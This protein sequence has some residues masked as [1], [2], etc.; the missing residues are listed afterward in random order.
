MAVAVFAA[1]L[2]LA[3]G[4]FARASTAAVIEGSNA[5]AFGLLEQ[6]RREQGNLFFSPFS[7]SSAL[8][9]TW[10]GAR[11]TTADQMAQ[12]LGLAV[13]KPDGE[14]HKAFAA[15]HKRLDA[16]AD[17]WEIAVANRLFGQKGEPF[18]PA[19]LGQLNDWYGAALEP[20]DFRRPESARLSINGWV[21]K[22]TRDK[23]K[24]L[25]PAGALDESTLLVVANAIWF[26]GRWAD[27]FDPKATREE[28]FHVSPRQ[29]SKVPIMHRLGTFGFFEN[30]EV[31]LVELPYQGN[32][33]AMVVV[34]PRDRFGLTA[35]EQRLTAEGFETLTGQ[36]RPVGVD[37][38]LPKFQITWEGD[39]SHDLQALGMRGAFSGEA[40]FSG[41]SR[42]GGLFISQV[43]HKAFVE[44]N[45]E[46]TE[47]AAATAVEMARAMSPARPQSFLADHPF[48]FA[49]IERESRAILF[50]GRVA[51]PAAAG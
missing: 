39:L 4:G 5:F 30:D 35:L 22:Q 21:E 18:L 24:E 44:V 19:F 20:V 8:A 37:V 31:S 40:D 27:E 45:E 23:V 6:L 28:P 49:I 41:I 10:A 43:R 14:V 9:M 33:L 25:L 2:G 34:L 13:V 16:Q 48:L 12:V 50:L 38:G 3:W 51:D 47:A 32:E 7:L 17:G 26:E 1:C 15:M 11:G 29:T 46:G 36:M 42:E